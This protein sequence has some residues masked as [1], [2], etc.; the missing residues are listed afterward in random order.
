MKTIFRKAQSEHPYAG[1]YADLCTQICRLELLIRGLKASKGNI[2]KCEFRKQMLTYCRESFEALLS[3]PLT[4][5]KKQDEKEEDRAEREFK[6]KHKLFGNIE[7]VGELYK[8]QIITDQV[9]F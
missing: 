8:S 7:F 1:F 2:K 9:M 5:E 4:E 3:T 6:T